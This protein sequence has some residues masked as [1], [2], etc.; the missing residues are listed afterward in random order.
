[1]VQR[2][3]RW[4][5]IKPTLDRRLLFACESLSTTEW[6]RSAWPWP[7]HRSQHS[8]F[9]V[10]TDRFMTAVKALVQC[11]A[12]V[13]QRWP[14]FDPSSQ[15]TPHFYSRLVQCWPSVCYAGPTLNQPWMKSG[16]FAGMRDWWL[17]LAVYLRKHEALIQCCANVGPHTTKLA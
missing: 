2:P 13:L 17:S 7:A 8:M 16:V 3:H 15:Q 12:N 1:M 11:C 6:P 4:P 14:S 5:S 9:Y 10:A